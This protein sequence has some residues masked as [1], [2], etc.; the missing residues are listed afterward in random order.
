MKTFVGVTFVLLW[1]STRLF[2]QN[3]PDT[4]WTQT[5]GGDEF[6]EGYSVQQTLDGGYIIAGYTDSFGAGRSDIW[7]IKTD[8]LGDTLWTKTFGGNSYDWGYSVQQTIDGGYIIAGE[9]RSFDVESGDI[10][11]IK[12][13]ESGDTLWTKTFGGNGWDSGNCVQQTKDEGYVII[14]TTASF[15]TDPFEK[16]IWLIK[17]DATG[18]TL[19]TNIFG[20]A[21]L[22]D[23]GHCVQQTSDEGYILIGN[24]ESFGA[25]EVDIWLIK[26]D[27]W[28]DTLWTKCFGGIAGDE[29]YYVQQTVDGGYILTGAV[30][31]DVEG[32]CLLKTDET[33]NMLWTKIFERLFGW[34]VGLTTDKGYIIAGGGFLLIKTDEQGDTL[35][36][37]S[38]EEYND[39]KSAQQTKDGGYIVTG[40]TYSMERGYDIFLIK[41][42]PELSNIEIDNQVH[43][44]ST[45][46]LKQNYPNPFNPSTTIEF[47]LPKSEYVELR[48]YNIL[49][50]EVSTLV[51]NKLNQGN[52]T[53][54]FDG[55]NLASGIYYY[56]LTAGDYR[57][58]KKMILLR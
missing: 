38:I 40:N 24:T 3:T 15:G 25:G 14:G 57:E 35:W 41:V 23:L 58:V 42:A 8:A 39:G 49:G 11:L 9:T 46:T 43:I 53:Y 20:G 44:A 31:L 50:K 54:Q 13:D 26:T 27:E 52:H 47:T 36:T 37:K 33:G 28:G 6:D 45:F 32:A 34:A 30:D 2:P 51:S 16:N 29:G 17:T 1:Y 4:V 55:K 21:I 18:D 48:V 5:F 10:W 19:W 7:L 12:T 56:Q 22:D